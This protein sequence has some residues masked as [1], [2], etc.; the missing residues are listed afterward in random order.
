[1]LLKNKIPEDKNL[2]SFVRNTSGEILKMEY[3]ERKKEWKIIKTF[4][5][6]LAM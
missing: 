3:R 6:S 1:M 4:N 5:R 2:I